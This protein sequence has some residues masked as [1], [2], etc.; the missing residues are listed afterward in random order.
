[1]K[2]YQFK[3]IGCDAE[4]DFEV[5]LSDEEFHLLEMIAKESKKVSTYQ[6]MPWIEIELINSNDPIK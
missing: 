2:Q 6:C 1:M 3:I 5:K 4:T